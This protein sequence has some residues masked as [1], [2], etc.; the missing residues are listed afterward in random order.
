MFMFTI[1]LIQYCSFSFQLEQIKYPKFNNFL[2]I[3][4]ILSRIQLDI[5]GIHKI[6]PDLTDG[7]TLFQDDVGWGESYTRHGYKSIKGKKIWRKTFFFNVPKIL[8]PDLEATIY[9]FLPKLNKEYGSHPKIGKCSSGSGNSIKLRGGTHSDESKKSAHCYIFHYEYEGGKCNNFQKEYP[10]PD[11]A[12][13][14][15]PEDNEFPNWIG[16][17]MGFKCITINT[18]G[19]KKVEF[20][21]FF[22]PSAKIE[23]GKLVSTND[24]KLRYHGF[25]E[26]QFKNKKSPATNPIF[27]TNWG[28]YMEFR[29][30]NADKQTIAYCASLREIRLP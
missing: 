18:I 7:T 4:S 24:W 8:N 5:F 9:V 21:A 29:M 30:D 26:G 19:D 28:K 22:D 16:K 2:D 11:Y 25:D 13:Y 23:N 17:V 3:I 27:K 12:K 6:F 20:Y 15:L 14:T 10:H 1:P